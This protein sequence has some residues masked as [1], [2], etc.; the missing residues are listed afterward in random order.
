[1]ASVTVT[2]PSAGTVGS[3]RRWF[4]G[5]FSNLSGVPLGN[6]LSSTSGNRWLLIVSLPTDRS[7]AALIRL[8]TNSSSGGSG[9]GAD[10]N[11][12][13]ESRG[14]VTL[15]SG[16][17]TFTYVGLRDSSNTYS[18]SFSGARLTALRAFATEVAD[19]TLTVTFNDNP[20]VGTTGGTLRTSLSSRLVV[21]TPTTL[22][23]TVSTPTK[24][25]SGD[26]TPGERFT[27]R[28]VVTNSGSATSPSTT[29]RWR[30]STNA[31]I[32]TS[33][34]QIGTDSV[35]ALG[36]NRTGVETFTLSAPAT[37][38]TY[39]YGATVDAV[40]NESNTRNNASGALRVVVSTAP[41][42]ADNTGDAQSWTV[43]TSISTLTV[44]RASGN[45]TPTYAVVGSLP[46]GISFSPSN[47]RL[48]GRP[49]RVGNGTIRVRAT[50]SV[51]SADWTVAYSVTTAGSPDLV[52]STPTKTPTGNLTPSQRFTLRAV[53]TNNGAGDAAATT[54]RWRRSTN[55][56]ISA[57]DT[58]V[59]TDSVRALSPNGTSTET[60][61][62]TAP[63]TPGTYYYGA[64][65]DS[66]T[67]ESTTT[68]NNSGA[69]TV[70]VVRPAETIALRG[71]SGGRRTTSLSAT[72]S[73]T[74]QTGSPDLV[75]STPTKTPTGNLTPLQTF[76][77]RAVVTN[78]GDANSP[79]TTLRWRRSTNDTISGS[80]TQI[81]TDTVGALA[82]GGT[83]VETFTRPGPS[84]PGTYYFGATVDSV[85]NESDTGNNASG[86]LA[87]VV[88]AATSGTIALRGTAG[89]TRTTSLS[90]T[91]SVGAQ[92]G[93][94][95]LVVSTPTKTPTGDLTPRQDFSLRAVVTNNG[96]AT[97]PSTTLRWYRSNN[98]TI[99]N[100]DIQLGTDSVR[101][102]GP[103]ETSVE[104][105]ALRSGSVPG[106]YY[107]GAVVDSVTGETTV[108]NQAS[109]AIT[110]RVVSATTTPGTIALSGTAG[111]T[112]STSLSA[113]LSVTTAVVGAPDLVVST[114]TRSPTG[115][116]TPGKSF[117]LTTVVTNN[118]DANSAST[119]LKWRRSTNNVISTGDTLIGSDGVSAL[120][121]GGTSTENFTLA[122]PSTPGTYYYGATVDAVVGEG[123]TNNNAS[124][125]LTVRVVAV[126]TTAPDLVV[127][128]PTRNPTGN[129]TPSE[130]FTL[131][132]VV[133]NSGDANSP[134]TTLRWRRS[135]NDN[136]TTS[137]PQIGTDG[138]GAL[139]P[140]GTNTETFTLAAPS[141]PGTYY[142][143]ATVDSVTGESSTT[144]NSS[145]ATTVRV[146][147]DTTTPGTIALR[148]TSGGRLGT[149][150]SARLVVTSGGSPDLVVST[151][152]RNPSGDLTVR[153]R[154]TLT[155][156]VTN[157]G[158]ANSPSGILRWRRSTNDV[159]STSDPL[160]GSD[161]VSALAPNGTN[162][163]T[164][165]LSAPSTPGTYYYGATVD[166]VA[167]ESN[168]G[169]NSSGAVTVVVVTDATA[170][171]FADSTGDAQSWTVGTSISTLTVP[172]ASGNPTP[173]Y[174]VVD[175]LPDGISFNTSSRRLT[176]RPTED[177]SGTITIRA[178]NTEGS[179]D[180][181]VDYAVGGTG[182]VTVSTPTRNPSGNLTPGQSFTLTT[183][184]T[185]AGSGTSDATT[186]RWRR[187]TNNSIDT[188]DTQIG[189]DAVSKLAPSGTSTESL[190]LTAPTTPGTYYYGA[191]V[192]SISLELNTGNNNSGA[193]TVVVAALEAPSFVSSSGD[194]QS[195]VIGTTVSFLTVPRASG[196]PTPTYSASGLPSGVSF[197]SSTRRISG[198][199][200]GSP[201]SGT[202][203]I[204]ATNREGT[205]TYTIAWSTV[206]TTISLVGTASGNLATTLSA[207][208]SVTSRLTPLKS[209]E[210]IGTAG[211]TLTTGLN[212]TLTAEAPTIG[213]TVVLPWNLTL[214]NIGHIW[215]R[216]SGSPSLGSTLS[217]DGME[218]FLRAV[219]LPASRDDFSSSNLR[220]E[221]ST[222]PNSDTQAEFS[223]RMESVGVVTFSSGT[224]SVSITGL[225]DTTEPYAWNMSGT[226]LRAFRT[227]ANTAAGSDLTIKFFLPPLVAL[228]GTAG[229]TLATEVG[230]TL[231]VTT[232]LKT[233]ALVGIGG[234]TLTT[235][236]SASLAV[237]TPL[238]TVTL[239]G[240]GGGTL[241]TVL[242]GTLTVV[243]PPKTVPLIGIGGG[244]LVT[245][246]SAPLTVT[247][248]LKTVAL[249]GTGGGTLE[250][251]LSADLTVT[252]PA[253]V[254]P[255]FADD[256]GDA[257]SWTTDTAIAAITVPEAS[258]N[259]VP[260]Y[261]AVG[262][263][264][265][266]VVFNAGT[267]VISGT[268]TQE[269]SGTITIRATNTEGS[270]DWTVAYSTVAG[271]S[272]GDW[273]GSGYRT[274]IV[275]ALVPVTIALPDITSQNFT[276]IGTADIVVASDMSIGQVER[277]AG[278]QPTLRLRRTTTSTALF[279]KYFGDSPAVY[280]Q[281]ELFLVIRNAANVSVTVP[282]TIS[283]TGGGF[284]NWQI[285]DN[286]QLSL[287][288]GLRT[289]DRFVLAMA[290][291][292]STV[293][294]VGTSGG[295]LTT[296]LSATLTTTTPS[297]S[298]ALIGTSGGTLDTTLSVD[299]TVAISTTKELI[300]TTGGTLT[301]ELTVALTVAAITLVELIGDVGG[302]L[303]T[304][305][306][307]ALTVGA[308]TS[309][310]IGTVGGTLETE[311]SVTL[312]VATFT[313]IS[314][315][316]TVGGTL[317]TELSV[318][319]TVGVAGGLVGTVGGTLETE[320]SVALTVGVGT[321]VMLI[322]TT[323]GTL[324]TELS[325]FLGDLP[326]VVTGAHSLE[327]WVSGPASVSA[328]LG[329]KIVGKPDSFGTEKSLG[330][331][332]DSFGNRT[333][334]QRLT[335]SNFILE[336]GD[337]WKFGL[338][339]TPTSVGEQTVHVGGWRL[340]SGDS[341]SDYED[342]IYPGANPRAGALGGR[343]GGRLT[344][345]LDTTL[346]VGSSVKLTGAVGGTLTTSLRVALTVR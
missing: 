166:A 243:T 180:W 339:F 317:E 208:L 77:L 220:L 49:T 211:G 324:E 11:S 175:S 257:Q 84:V 214:L 72:L 71:T 265:T 200:S 205:D 54:L 170:P 82:P 105:F 308:A 73:V 18:T 153:E 120:G 323:G 174:A 247:T 274:P 285:D 283:N 64:T 222:N 338:R 237:T 44:P 207:T 22:D 264:P 224:E 302:T 80:D 126:D 223:T 146:V 112:R 136:I 119:T 60:V 277:H 122:A 345:T 313:G 70:R 246:L 216:T 333:D 309:G 176:G 270:D 52:V 242:S 106:P 196:N 125:A 21:T 66:V 249:V 41:T 94:P 14:S 209:V 245:E 25:V 169:N 240:I 189:T 294:L 114:P 197:N 121:P 113:T 312:T 144:N 321:T 172:T 304:E 33:D 98:T 17:D 140:N 291:P 184:V 316:G 91:L 8:S 236:L 28:A 127:S 104:T 258:G 193:I 188:G 115:D 314:L 331:E 151:P 145:G 201:Q 204:T 134:G 131:T 97:S 45:P 341:I 298:V 29:L 154:F 297:K 202:I 177:G 276:P 275:L 253:L 192:D 132:A 58:Q 89:G 273:D 95:D 260:T 268:P 103:G 340:E 171:V 15:R 9:S 262:A 162:T 325:V 336:S 16:S 148:G 117:T 295:T 37:P 194:A 229:G 241:T 329:V 62:L 319:L 252:T 315:V 129:L 292:L 81:G 23:L 142:Y 203:T 191:T 46:S 305:L 261:A 34:T 10:F 318:A 232:P 53:V 190:T 328:Q 24:N 233:V 38:G 281:T 55:D 227:F 199:P 289:G 303:E 293:E 337:D 326:P 78:N 161:G 3:Y 259:P 167:G 235:A 300:G 13:M 35:G 282:F 185:N 332:T 4:G 88:V 116:L 213:I 210:L 108:N 173:T 43:G 320:L 1:M 244:T 101:A 160:I 186:V 27:L 86:A 217:D 31:T 2:I 278:P 133:T 168:S 256:T 141:A 147:A 109:G 311:L 218:R 301:T 99:S 212:A 306:S 123:A 56:T 195:W 139:A 266:G 178:T 135:T 221:V 65:V 79:S 271:L 93:A 225:K 128:T 343:T 181:T 284:S 47:R 310:L 219:Y 61:T 179:A 342:R 239:V 149:T 39:Y 7:S 92:T 330:G 57:S 198:T 152:T 155:A 346:T 63:S 182:D 254:E 48:T 67:G 12:R 26:L 267:R 234:G 102:L 215:S 111:G 290:E 164:F 322:G 32:T 255:S 228:V 100:F 231:T 226:E 96:D 280:E 296:E 40:I 118:G 156:I 157:S 30:R 76:T 206:I 307:V 69:L 159:I 143:G 19:R 59:G 286:D 137:D 83:S 163:E 75:V 90:A 110:V 248:N 50:N 5:T 124:G 6:T 150:L 269:E 299:L 183:V 327:V 158:D 238:K 334:W 187:S 42:F 288:T 165:T 335:H 230:A 130:S 250:T 272:I 36:P 107:Y 20:L 287:L 87:V 279:S 138:V 344:T 251:T 51:G 74:S 85:V 263:L 68:N